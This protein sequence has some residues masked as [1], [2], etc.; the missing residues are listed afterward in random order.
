[1]PVSGVTSPPRADPV[2]GTLGRV[3]GARDLAAVDDVEHGVEQQQEPGPAGVDDAGLLEHGEQLGRAVE[4]D[5]AGLAG[6]GE[7]VDQRRAAGRSLP[8]RLGALPHDG[9]DGALHGPLHGLVRQPPTPRVSEA[10]STSPSTASWSRTTS[11]MPRRSWERMTPELPRAPMSDPWATAL[12]TDAMSTAATAATASET[13][14]RVRV[15]FV[16]VSPSGTGYTLRRLIASWC[17]SR[18]SPNAAMARPSSAAPRRSSV[19]VTAGHPID[20][21]SPSAAHVTHSAL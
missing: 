5:L 4:G 18:A 8:R 3:R 19:V 12:Q 20:G 21:S 10:A 1:M 13:D 14:R 16:P 17:A 2:G 11:V 6:A 7:H 9:E 15:M